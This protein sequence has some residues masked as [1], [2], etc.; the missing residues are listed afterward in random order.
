M[1]ELLDRLSASFRRGSPASRET[2][3]ALGLP[4][5]QLQVPA[6]W[7]LALLVMRPPPTTHTPA[8]SSPCCVQDVITCL[9]LSEAVYKAAEG[10]PAAAV[11]ALNDLRSQFPGGL[12]P[13]ISVQFCRRSAAHRYMLARTTSA[14][15]CA[16]MGTKQPRDYW[17]DAN[18]RWAEAE[19]VAA[20]GSGVGATTAEEAAQLGAAAAALGQAVPDALAPPPAVHRGFL[21]R[22]QAVQAE[23]LLDHAQQQGVRLVLCGEWLLHPRTAA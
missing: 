12:A 14:L 15:Y 7:H 13:L 6:G 17:A 23:L 2:P 1:V 5:D 11:A 22:S 3:N 19:V 16:F 4:P 20:A 8:S 18:L 10:P 21:A 9:L